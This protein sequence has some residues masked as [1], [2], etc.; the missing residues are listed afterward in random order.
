LIPIVEFLDEVCSDFNVY[1]R[2]EDVT[3]LDSWT[4]FKLAYRLDA[5]G[6]AF[7][8]A[9]VIASQ[10]QQQA[11]PSQDQSWA[12]RKPPD[13]RAMTAEELAAW[14]PGA[15]PGLGMNVGLFDYVKAAEGA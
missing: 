3:R 8:R 6:G 10:E 7:M 2:V 13:S 11:A 1:H 4:F 9:I 14:D 12:P 5:Y 15:A